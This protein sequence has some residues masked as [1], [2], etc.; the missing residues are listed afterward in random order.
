M[1]TIKTVLCRA[2]ALQ[3]RRV[4]MNIAAVTALGA[5]WT[6]D[7]LVTSHAPVVL[8]RV[9]TRDHRHV[10]V[11]PEPRDALDCV[12]AASALFHALH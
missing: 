3:N 4:V 10:M 2:V 9:T 6:P 7:L 8:C 1:A 11:L 12:A 5:M